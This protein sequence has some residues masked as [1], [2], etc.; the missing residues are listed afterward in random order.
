MEWLLLTPLQR[1]IRREQ[2]RAGIQLHRQLEREHQKRL[3]LAKTEWRK[4]QDMRE[5]QL[6]QELNEAEQNITQLHARLR[7]AEGEK[8]NQH[9]REQQLWRDLDEAENQHDQDFKDFRMAL[10]LTSELDKQLAIERGLK[11]QTNIIVKSLTSE[12]HNLQREVERQDEGWRASDEEDARWLQELEQWEL[13]DNDISAQVEIEIQELEQWMEHSA[14]QQSKSTNSSGEATMT[15]M[16]QSANAS[17]E[18]ANA[19]MPQRANASGEAA[20][21]RAPQRASTSGEA[22][23]TRMPQSANASGEAA[24]ARTS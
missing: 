21:A 2:K 7:K 16:P 6:W 13:M 23:M 17:G 20:K 12:I 14:N 3:Q 10:D 18:A 4:V 5:Q 24:S 9:A 22:A 11:K 1:Q 8:Q 19:R 15:R